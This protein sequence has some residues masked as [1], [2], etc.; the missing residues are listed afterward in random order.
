V[1][2]FL[3]ATFFLPLIDLAP[4]QAQLVPVQANIDAQAQRRLREQAESAR[5][6]RRIED[7]LQKI[8]PAL[9]SKGSTANTCRAL[10]ALYEL[11]SEGVRPKE[12]LQRAADL[13]GLGT[14]STRAP[15]NYLLQ[16][17]ESISGKLNSEIA[18]KMKSG[19][20]PPFPL[21][22]YQP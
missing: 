8:V 12:S 7:N 9:S 18:G 2:H 10:A 11:Q 21:P 4:V 22:T 19:P 6:Q 14:E 17:W 1:R 13:S 20:P 3:F 5:R 16:C 15:S